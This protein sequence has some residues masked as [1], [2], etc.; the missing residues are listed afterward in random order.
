MSQLFSFKWNL[1][2]FL[3][4]H[5]NIK[6]IF[7]CKCTGR[8]DIWLRRKLVTGCLQTPENNFMARKIL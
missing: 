7:V 2:E 5:E 8:Q 1:K 4:L 3:L 6:L